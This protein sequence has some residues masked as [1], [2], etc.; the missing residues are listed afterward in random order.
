M[1][2]VGSG[3]KSS[4]IKRL[5]DFQDPPSAPNTAIKEKVP[6]SSLQLSE[7][8]Q[9][10]GTGRGIAATGID[11]S[12]KKTDALPDIKIQ[13]SGSLKFFTNAYGKRITVMNTKDQGTSYNTFSD[14]GL[15]IILKDNSGKRD[16]LVFSA[17]T[18]KVPKN[19]AIYDNYF[20]VNAECS[21]NVAFELKGKCSGKM[22]FDKN[23]NIV[24][25]LNEKD[26]L[27]IDGKDGKT[28]LQGPFKINF[29]PDRDAH[30]FNVDY[31]GSDKLRR[32]NS[33][34]GKINLSGNI[35]EKL[36]DNFHFV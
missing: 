11:F 2:A 28:I 35:D 5:L 4:T 21:A 9:I 3:D 15:S 16:V 18:D 31:T 13:E 12:D 34:G 6:V 32:Q 23:H 7:K 14:E 29:N 1:T 25:E 22:Y 24:I 19:S 8:L 27:V 30:D 33:R 36:T 10:S 20:N 26:R 17:M